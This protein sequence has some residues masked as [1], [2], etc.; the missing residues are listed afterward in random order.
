MKAKLPDCSHF[1]WYQFSDSQIRRYCVLYKYATFVYFQSDHS[2][3]LIARHC[4]EN[5]CVCK[6]ECVLVN[7]TTDWLSAGGRISGKQSFS[8]WRFVC[9]EQWLKPC[10]N[11]AAKVT[12]IGNTSDPRKDM[13]EHRTYF[14]LAS[15][16]L[17]GDNQTIAPRGSI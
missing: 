5:W 2:V 4:N 8:R 13:N 17:Q 3:L 12:H 1:Y 6:R 10:T 9:Y 14:R 7:S 16:W 15:F 11:V